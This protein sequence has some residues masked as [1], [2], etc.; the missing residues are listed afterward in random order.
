MKAGTALTQEVA[1][2]LAIQALT[3][4]AE[5]PER[6]SRF[7]AVTG[8]APDEI[9]AAARA[10]GFLTGVLEHLTADERLLMDFAKAASLDPAEIGKALATLGGG[11]PERGSA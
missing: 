10:P 3:F 6:L 7:L 9:R 2:A 4:L 8:I 11:A 1:E 5:E